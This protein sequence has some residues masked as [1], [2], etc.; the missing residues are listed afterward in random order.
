M[1]RIC[2]A[3]FVN[4]VSGDDQAAIVTGDD[5]DVGCEHTHDGARE[6]GTFYSATH[7][8]YINVV[9]LRYSSVACG[10]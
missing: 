7:D 9:G 5:L 10:P 6:I 1:H 8:E 2:S 3:H 4:N